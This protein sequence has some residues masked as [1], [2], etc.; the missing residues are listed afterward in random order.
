MDYKLITRHFDASKELQNQIDKKMEKMVKFDKWINHID[1]IING[2]GDR[3]ST[4]INA[5]LEHKQINAKVEGMDAYN[6]FAKAFLKI[7]RQI[8]EFESRVTDHHGYR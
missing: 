2:E 7:E 4:E 6:T 5:F 3:K 1:I 8:K